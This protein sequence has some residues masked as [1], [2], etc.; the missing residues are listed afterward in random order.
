MVCIRKQRNP[1]FYFNIRWFKATGSK[2]QEIDYPIGVETSIFQAETHENVIKFVQ[3]VFG[4][5]C[6]I[7]RQHSGKFVYKEILEVYQNGHWEQITYSWWPCLPFLHKKSAK[8][9]EYRA[10]QDKNI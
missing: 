2:E 1:K 8:I 6:R 3:S 4:D 7:I 10:I 5:G 9:T